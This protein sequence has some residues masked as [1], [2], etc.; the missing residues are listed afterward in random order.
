M[1]DLQTKALHVMVV[2]KNLDW[3]EHIH[4]I[5]EPG[6][7]FCMTI[8]FPSDGAYLVY[9]DF[10]PDKEPEE[11]QQQKLQVGSAVPQSTPL[12]ETPL[13]KKIG[14]YEVRLKM[15]PTNPEDDPGWKALTFHLT[16]SGNPV[17]DLQALDTLGHLLILRDGAEDVVYAHST[18]GEATG[19]VRAMAHLPALPTGVGEHQHRGDN[20]GP[21]VTFHARFGKPGLYKLWAEF[22]PGKD[23]VT[24]DFVVAIR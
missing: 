8:V 3:F 2:G 5:R 21:D 22:H 12:Q 16:R 7:D 4:P 10:A 1:R 17:H 19:G 6:G 15:V 24:A 11:M 14:A 20:L 18:D 13:T 9:A 23:H